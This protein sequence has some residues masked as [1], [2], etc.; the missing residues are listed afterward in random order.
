M[1]MTNCNEVMKFK[2]KYY[3]QTI[4]KAKGQGKIDQLFK[5]Q[6]QLIT[7]KPALKQT[8]QSS[9]VSQSSFIVIYSDDDDSVDMVIA[10]N[11]AQQDFLMAS[12]HKAPNGSPRDFAQ[13]DVPSQIVI[14]STRSSVAD[15]YVADDSNFV[16]SKEYVF[17]NTNAN[18]Q[19]GGAMLNAAVKLSQPNG[20]VFIN[21]AAKRNEAS[22]LI[23][24]GVNLNQSAFLN[25]GH[26]YSGCVTSTQQLLH[27]DSQVDY[28]QGVFLN[29]VSVTA[30]ESVFE[31][32]NA[33]PISSSAG[34]ITSAFASGLTSQEHQ[35]YRGNLR[36][37]NDDKYRWLA[38]YVEEIDLMM[39]G[40][41]GHNVMCD[42]KKGGSCA[43]KPRGKVT[44]TN[45]HDDP[46]NLVMAGD[47]N[48]VNW[49]RVTTIFWIPELWFND[50]V[51]HMPCS[52]CRDVKGFLTRVGWNDS[53]PRRVSSLGREYNI[54]CLR[55]QCNN[56]N[57]GKQVC[58]YDFRCLSQLPDFI[59]SQLPVAVYPKTCLDSVL[60]DLVQRCAVDSI[61]FSQIVAM[62]KEI[63]NAYYRRKVLE[64]NDFCVRKGNLGI[65]KFFA[66]PKQIRPFSIFA[67]GGSTWQA[68][69]PTTEVTGDVLSAD[70][71][72][73]AA[74]LITQQPQKVFEAM[75]TVMNENK[76][77]VGSYYTQSKSLKEIRPQLLRINQRYADRGLD[78]PS[79]F[80]IDNC[81]TDGPFLK[82]VFPKLATSCDSQTP[83]LS[84]RLKFTGEVVLCNNV[85]ILSKMLE[86]VSRSP[87][88]GFAAEWTKSNTL[89]VSPPKVQVVQICN[90]SVCLVIQLCHFSGFPSALV[91]FLND[92]NITKVGNNIKGDCTRLLNQFGV[93]VSNIHDLRDAFQS[94]QPRDKAL[95][96]VK[97][98]LGS[99]VRSHLKVELLQG[100][101]HLNWGVS[102]LSASQVQYAVEDAF[103]SFL[104]YD[105]YVKSSQLQECKEYDVVWMYRQYIQRGCVRRSV[106]PPNEL[107]DRLNKVFC[108]FKEMCPAFITA[109][110]E[111]QHGRNMVHVRNGCLS[112]IPGMVMYVDINSSNSELNHYRNVRGTSGQEGF[113]RISGG[114]INAS[115]MS[116]ELAQY[117][118]MEFALRWN[119]KQASIYQESNVYSF[120]I[121]T[122]AKLSQLYVNNQT[123]FQS[124]IV[125]E[126]FWNL[127][128]DC[129]DLELFGADSYLKQQQL[130]SSAGT[131]GDTYEE[132]SI[133]IETDSGDISNDLVPISSAISGCAQVLADSQVMNLFV[134]SSLGYNAYPKCKIPGKFCVPRNFCSDEEIALFIGVLGS[135]ISSSKND[136]VKIDASSLADVWNAR[137]YQMLDQ[138]SNADNVLKKFS[139]KSAS[140]F[141]AFQQALKQRFM[142]NNILMDH[143]ESIKSLRKQLQLPSVFINQKTGNKFDSQ[144]KL[145]MGLHLPQPKAVQTS[146]SS[147]VDLEHREIVRIILNPSMHICSA[148]KKVQKM[149]LP[150][151]SKYTLQ[152]SHLNNVVCPLTQKAPTEEDK[153]KM[154]S[155]QKRIKD[156]YKYFTVIF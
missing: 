128:N 65:H 138:E 78:G 96:R 80:T 14:F 77:I 40:V 151:E 64:Y 61:S 55:Y 46:P 23:N 50:F 52:D 17:I 32:I 126:V 12:S 7:S 62:Y 13:S 4:C 91:A 137:I 92:S 63:N 70:H 84:M 53:G 72:I 28:D 98:D 35:T 85:Q 16:G 6:S 93:S 100:E 87:Y 36:W 45:I 19:V 42:F 15:Q 75:Y 116:V 24:T 38:R 25:A 108:S 150:G 142:A 94:E 68:Q 58:G 1:D 124:N 81:C 156:K 154:N 2:N 129:S 123:S 73:A 56:K 69:I 122:I 144:S 21:T 143:R 114:A 10:G 118:Y 119:T 18:I 76:M 104:L 26:P 148:Y 102:K 115:S 9:N 48:P 125:P 103:A 95:P 74:K 34:T 88:V 101:S 140:Q 117:L 109:D 127:K 31:N 139:L 106:P 97:M 49:C 111:A 146:S 86:A 39:Y 5:Q 135:F 27:V 67:G 3:H 105:Y 132:Q 60:S 11:N 8:L 120:D 29:T 130:L 113:H 133:L 99:I 89:S 149:K 145:R 41:S 112:D 54:I 107:A 134:N 153:R 121:M 57:C 83:S 152:N 20:E 59:Q 33:T 22:V 47:Q 79:A 110:M 44:W 51:K 30:H 82:T 71:T 66:Q 37:L 136:L 43:C 131:S 155:L 141:I 90:L 147:I